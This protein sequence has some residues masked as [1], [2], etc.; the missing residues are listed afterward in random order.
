VNDTTPNF[1]LGHGHNTAALDRIWA[2]VDTRL[3][4]RFRRS[5]TLFPSL[6]AGGLIALLG[7]GAIA[8]GAFD[9]LT[10]EQHISLNGVASE[11]SAI[12]DPH[13]DGST[14][15]V[16][17]KPNTFTGMVIDE[18]A[19]TVNIYATG[20]LPA[21]VDHIIASNPNIQVVVH[22]A[23]T[24]L[25]DATAAVD[26]LTTFLMSDGWGGKISLI[27]VA[28]AADG[29]IYATV[30]SEQPHLVKSDIVR[31]I[32][33]AAGMPVDVTIEAYGDHSLEPVLIP[34]KLSP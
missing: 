18:T 11:I 23:T 30:A 21:G 4:S 7:T 6:F 12:V 33:G 25:A 20:P 27:S 29:S 14:T 16:D 32:E 13:D 19:G 31:V 3:N 17:G 2:A 5:S 8:Y 15:T 34:G 9:G 10:H 24:S 26:R 22:K 1:R 28:P